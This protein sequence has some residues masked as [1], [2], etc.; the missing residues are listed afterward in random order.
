MNWVPKFCFGYG[1]LASIFVF[2]WHVTGIPGYE[3]SISAFTFLILH[4]IIMMLTF[5]TRPGPPY[6]APVFLVTS[7]RIRFARMLLFAAGSNF[8]VWFV[9][10]AFLNRSAS[11]R[12]LDALLSSLFLLNTIYIAIHWAR[13]ENLFLPSTLVFLSNPIHYLV[14]PQRRA[15]A[16]RLDKLARRVG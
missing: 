11:V 15:D 2:G 6:W 10:L 1:V 14:S 4:G 9:V 13:P 16:R 5:H 8:V 12:T 3:V 7:D